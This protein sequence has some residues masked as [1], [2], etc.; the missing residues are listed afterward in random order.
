MSLEEYDQKI[1]TH[2]D[3]ISAAT[4]VIERHINMMEGQP[5]FNT[6][7]KSDLNQIVNTLYR[8]FTKLSAAQA[9]FEELPVVE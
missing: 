3:F 6:I 2:L 7:A 8:V 9:K 5:D 4:E 1:G